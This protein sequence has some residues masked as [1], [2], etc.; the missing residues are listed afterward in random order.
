MSQ[1]DVIVERLD[2]TMCP[3]CDRPVSYGCLSDIVSRGHRAVYL[4][5]KCGKE[6]KVNLQ[7]AI[8]VI[9]VHIYF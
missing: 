6:F 1:D 9:N 7:N 2:G 5:C 4:V 3:S 8:V